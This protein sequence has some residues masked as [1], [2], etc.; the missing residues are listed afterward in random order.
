MDDHLIDGFGS[1]RAPARG[2]FRIYALH[3]R[4]SD[5]APIVT[6]GILDAS[7]D[8]S[9]QVEL[10]EIPRRWRR[11]TVARTA[12]AIDQGVSSLLVRRGTA[13]FQYAEDDGPTMADVLWPLRA[14]GPDIATALVLLRAESEHTVT[15]PSYE[16]PV[17]LSTAVDERGVLRVDV[18]S[19]IFH[20]PVFLAAADATDHDLLP[21][22]WPPLTQTEPVDREPEHAPFLPPLWRA[23]AD[24]LREATGQS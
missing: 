18:H 19:P 12:W 2:R 13:R 4:G 22:E 17:R 9:L 15:V 14:A 7:R 5:L 3:D 1:A 8:R 24:L 20:T 21:D 11:A 6:V 23:A 16:D 10:H